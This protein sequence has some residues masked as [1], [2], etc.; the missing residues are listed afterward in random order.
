MCETFEEQVQEIKETVV[1]MMFT[2]WFL[3]QS[4]DT[5]NI[6]TRAPAKIEADNR[7]SRFA[8]EFLLSVAECHAQL[9]FHLIDEKIMTPEEIQEVIMARERYF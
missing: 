7:E 1:G 5:W 4:S 9:Y 6:E 3:N 8:R 2:L